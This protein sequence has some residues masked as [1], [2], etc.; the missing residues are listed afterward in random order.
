MESSVCL[1]SALNTNSYVREENLGLIRKCVESYFLFTCIT[2]QILA[3]HPRSM[4]GLEELFQEGRKKV[5]PAHTW[6]VYLEEPIRLEETRN[7]WATGIILGNQ[8]WDFVPNSYVF[9]CSCSTKSNYFRPRYFLKYPIPIY[10]YVAVVLT[11]ITSNF[12]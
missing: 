4:D 12:C 11:G 5:P 6:Q 8:F 1:L 3:I 9:L 2:N 7:L 10:M